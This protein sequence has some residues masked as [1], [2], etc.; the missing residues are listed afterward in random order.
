MKEIMVVYI[1]VYYICI[2][3]Y[4]NIE[5]DMLMYIMLKQFHFV[6]MGVFKQWTTDRRC[7]HEQNCTI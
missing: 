4:V 5:L 6:V 7:C 2:I 3:D 1:Y